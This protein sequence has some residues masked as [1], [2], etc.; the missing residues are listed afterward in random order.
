MIGAAADGALHVVREVALE[1]AH[2]SPLV[3][4]HDV[5]RQGAFATGALVDGLEVG[6]YER[7]GAVPSVDLG[8]ALVAEEERAAVV[9][10][11][12]DQLLRFRTA[13]DYL[14]VGVTAPEMVRSDGEQ[15]A[16]AQVREE[17]ARATVFVARQ[18]EIEHVPAIAV[19]GHRLRK[20]DAVSATR[21]HVVH[22]DRSRGCVG[23]VDEDAAVR[24]V[25][26]HDVLQPGR[27][28]RQAGQVDGFHDLE[29]KHP[30]HYSA[31]DRKVNP[32]SEKKEN[33]KNMKYVAYTILSF[34]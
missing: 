24:I 17:Q 19:H 13:I 8:L 30:L 34:Y 5:S 2:L 7:G 20:Y 27:G 6:G 10:A 11:Q 14:A 15:T 1:D 25:V 33:S 26:G 21:G 3:I 31:H 12:D 22:Q 29:K 23:H 18:R 4:G 9:R 32:I 16:A 28:A